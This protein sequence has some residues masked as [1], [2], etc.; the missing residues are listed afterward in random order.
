MDNFGYVADSDERD[1]EGLEVPD[2]KW[3]AF[4]LYSHEHPT[5]I[6]VTS[7]GHPTLISVTIGMRILK[8]KIKMWVKMKFFRLFTMLILILRS[9]NIIHVEIS[10]HLIVPLKSLVL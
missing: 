3:V 5:H 10:C 2:M 9:F 8:L 6:S 1:D 4:H 7:H